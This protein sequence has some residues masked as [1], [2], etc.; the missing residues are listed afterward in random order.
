MLNLKVLNKII[1]S[2]SAE[3]KFVYQN[4]EYKI[5]SQGKLIRSGNLTE[6]SVKFTENI[7][8]I[9]D[10]VSS[11]KIEDTKVRKKI[12]DRKKVRICVD[13]LYEI[14]VENSVPISIKR[15]GS[16]FILIENREEYFYKDNSGSL[17]KS[18]IVN[19]FYYDPKSKKLLFEE[20]T[21]PTGIVK[22]INMD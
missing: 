21:Y 18:F 15:N 7:S 2:L 6:S 11:A 8:P 12:I 1:S 5:Y 22:R 10:R 16:D 20:I 17:I 13:Y 3:E 14:N 19:S 9:P 4:G